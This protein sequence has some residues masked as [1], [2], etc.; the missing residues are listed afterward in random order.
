MAVKLLS[1]ALIGLDAVP[2]EVEA[3]ISRG[4]PKTLIVGL[5]DV[6]VQ[7]ARERVKS[8]IKNSGY[9]FPASVIT[10]NLAPAHI[11]KNG[12]HYDL[13]IALALLKE[14]GWV[15][16][17]L[18]DYLFVGELSL[19]GDVRPINGILPMAIMAKEQKL[20]KFFIPHDNYQEAS[21][22]KGL[23]IIP[24]SNFQ[25]LVS[26]L[27]GKEKI[28]INKKRLVH[29]KVANNYIDMSFIRGHEKA[30]RALEI[31]AAGG[32]NILM[33]G[34]PGSGKSL[35]AKAMAGILPEMS[36]E[37]SITLT[38]IYSVAGLLSEKHGIVKERPFR[39]P[40]HST[41][42]VALV[43]GGSTPRPGEISLAHHGVLF[44]DELGEFPR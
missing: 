44:L 35:L 40:H 16:V 8:G 23:N 33:T 41:S 2:I 24:V 31:S 32:H 30:K 29:K 12:P 4:L 34:P 6:A 13:P 7:E 17:D 28:V 1:S 9:D 42:G 18:S 39:S 15:N 43:G 5:P 3:D 26:Y 25:Q 22:V 14:M 20:K 19:N 27:L 11:K 21:L 36:F 10:I 37:E 38:K